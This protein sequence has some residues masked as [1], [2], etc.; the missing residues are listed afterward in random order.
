MNS[1]VCNVRDWSTLLLAGIMQM[2]KAPVCDEK[3]TLEWVPVDRLVKDIVTLSRE[4]KPLALSY[5]SQHRSISRVEGMNYIDPENGRIPYS[6]L[7][8]WLAQFMNQQGH[9]LEF[10]PL[11]EW[12][13]N[14]PTLPE[15]NALYPLRDSIPNSLRT[16]P[17]RADPSWSDISYDEQPVHCPEIVNRYFTFIW[18]HF[19]TN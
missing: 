7:F 6:Q 14:L 19:V 12:V 15:E 1:G 9:T 10:L 3:V 18:N 5:S 13:E 2:G 4:M 11:L 17:P 16:R 8:A